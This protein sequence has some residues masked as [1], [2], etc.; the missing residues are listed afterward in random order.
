MLDKVLPVSNQGYNFAYQTIKKNLS[1]LCSD[2]LLT[3]RQYCLDSLSDSLE[4][5]QMLIYLLDPLEGYIR[6]LKLIDVSDLFEENPQPN[7]VAATLVELKLKRA[8]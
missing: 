8:H 1:L 3:Y 7:W 2:D 4:V 6:D 5:G